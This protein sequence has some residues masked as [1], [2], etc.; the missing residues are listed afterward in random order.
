MLVLALFYLLSFVGVYFSSRNF[1]HG[2]TALNSANKILNLT[3][4]AS[5]GL[6]TLTDNVGPSLEVRSAGDAQFAFRANL[7][8]VLAG[9]VLSKNLV[10]DD[11]KISGYLNDAEQALVQ[12]EHVISSIFS[13][14]P[15]LPKGRSA[16]D[17]E[18][19]RSELAVAGEFEA[20][21]KE[22]LRKAQIA[23]KGNS[24]AIFESVYATR[25]RPLFVAVAMGLLFF[26]FVL[27][28]GLSITRRLAI[29]VGNLI[30]ATEEV[31][32]GNLGYQAEVLEQDEIGRLTSAFNQMVQS[33]AQGRAELRG[34]LDRTRR[35]QTITAAFSEALGPDQV[36]EII[37]RQGFEALGASSGII[38]MVTEGG[39]ELEIKRIEG[40]PEDMPERS[41]RIPVSAELP[42]AVAF[43]YRK[44]IFIESMRSLFEQFP[45]TRKYVV[46]PSERSLIAVPLTVGS[47]AFGVLFLN[48]QGARQ[49]TQNEKD[50]VVALARQC[51]Q[52][53]H[54]AQLFED[55]H[56]AVQAR[57][58][59]LSIASHELKTPLTPLRLQI[60]GLIRHI[61]LRANEP[62]PVELLTRIAE[63]S[64][65]QIS[66]LA[67]LIEDLLDVSRITAGRL[68]LSP[69]EFNLA[70]MLED[71][72]NRYGHQMQNAKTPIQIEADPKLSGCFDRVRIEQVLI[73][74]ITNAA[75]YAPGQPVVIRLQET[76]DKIQLKVQDQGPGIAEADQQR[77]FDRFERV[78][79]RDNVGGLGLGLYISKQIVEAHGGRIYVDSRPGH[80]STFVVE[81]PMAN[82]SE[83]GLGPQALSH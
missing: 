27:V 66:R 37:V 30:L 50:F 32:R 23:L 18:R 64:D 13:K 10:A 25:Y 1:L 77:I 48:F 72:V 56:Q 65:R 51:A 31:A 68:S 67:H 82:R 42:I 29:S 47:E 45:E 36:N 46:D 24:D 8:Q 43:R 81:L 4:Q 58:E 9:I 75:K 39:E 83:S 6:D 5:E 20:D 73:N 16:T 60:Q 12:Y 7:E 41:R 69:E 63:N 40:F 80:G 2:L 53:L 22:S 34:S 17:V 74:L 19:I 11:P 3:T 38:A 15:S 78:R 76:Q 26:S 57:D 79:E 61:K 33:L 62:I 49:F 44:P 70:E 21:A 71:V 54:R 52:A 14:L 28:A 59:F 55:A 35:L